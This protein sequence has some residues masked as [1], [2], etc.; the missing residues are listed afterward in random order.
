[1]RA[2]RDPMGRRLHTLALSGPLLGRI[3]DVSAFTKGVAG[4]RLF[5]PIGRPS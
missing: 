5:S 1:L 2:F 3:R 4:H